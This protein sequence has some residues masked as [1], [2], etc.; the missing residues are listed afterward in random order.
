[1]GIRPVKGVVKKE[2]KKGTEPKSFISMA[3]TGETPYSDDANLK[4]QALVEVLNIKLI[5][6]LREELSGIYGGGM[7][8]SLN[9]NP[10]SNYSINVSLPCGPENVDKLIKATL[11]EIQKI[12]DNGPLE[13]DLNKVKETWMK[14]YQE[15]VKDNNYWLSKLQQSVE[16]GSNTGDVLTFEKRI[17]AL[18]PK[19]VKEAANLY[20]NMKNYLQVVL[21]PEK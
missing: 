11:D 19:D 8:G 17:N 10:Y 4:L 15:D 2:V 3:F 14:Q 1:M 16:I 5:E 18:T 6:S 21:N 7:R 13:A 12:K 20:F 9:K